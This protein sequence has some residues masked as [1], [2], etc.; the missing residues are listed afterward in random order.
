VTNVSDHYR[1]R[2]GRLE[3]V[4][5]VTSGRIG[6]DHL[7][8]SRRRFIFLVG[9]AATGVWLAST[10]LVRFERFGRSLAGSCSFCGNDWADVNALLESSGQSTKICDECVGI[11][12]EV[13]GE[14]VGVQFPCDDVHRHRPSFED[15]RFRQ[16]VE[17]M[18]RRLAAKR[19][20]SRSDAMNGLSRGVDLTR[21][22][23][24]LETFQCSFCRTDRKDAMKLISGPRVFICDSC[25]EDAAAEVFDVLRTA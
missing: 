2:F 19:D 22:D 4:W 16:H 14:E 17:E 9:G 18:R 12:C 3:S 11:C 21:H 25:V 10:R 7:V 15:E 13:F 8:L 24:S 20:A 23:A 1:R 5:P 6:Y